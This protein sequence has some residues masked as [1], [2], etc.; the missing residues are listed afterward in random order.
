MDNFIRKARFS[1]LVFVCKG[2][3]E[4]QKNFAAKRKKNAQN[5]LLAETVLSEQETPMV[6]PRGGAGS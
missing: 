2:S 4:G 3:A 6:L 1:L 5:R